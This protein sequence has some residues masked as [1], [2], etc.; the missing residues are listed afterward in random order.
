MEIPFFNYKDYCKDLNYETLLKEVLESGYLIGGPFIEQVEK[1]IQTLTGIKNCVCV[2]NATDAMEIM[3]DFVKLPLNSNVL[4]PAHTMLATASAV[5]VNGLNPIPVDVDEKSYMVEIEQL[6]KCDLKNVSA[7]IITQLNGLVADMNPIKDFCENHNIALMEDSA[8]GIGAF[9]NGIHSG[10]WGIGGCLSFYP[11]KVIGCLGDGGALLT[12]NDK[13]ATFA[14]SVRDHGRGEGLEAINW[15][16]NSRLDSLNARVIIERLKLLDKLISKR[17]KLAYVYLEKLKV[18][19]DQGIINL[20]PKYSTNSK[21]I[22]TFQNFEIKVKFRDDLIKFL[23]TNNI[24]TIKQWGGFSIAHFS[25]LGFNIKDFP[26][27]QKLFD[28]LLLLPLNHMMSIEEVE[29]ISEKVLSFYNQ[30]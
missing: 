15:G 30:K 6:I 18:L 2:A 10:S 20:P 23:K 1:D 11:A 17:R 21:D 5:K 9:N 24:S 22:G 19:E 7:I 3:F 26:S 27:T 28:K 25:K 4:V 13:M 8:Q 12:N 14:R 16:R 29:Y